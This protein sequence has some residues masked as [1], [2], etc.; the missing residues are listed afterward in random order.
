MTMVLSPDKKAAA[1]AKKANARP[2]ASAAAENNSKT[3]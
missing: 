1:N 3:A 2:A